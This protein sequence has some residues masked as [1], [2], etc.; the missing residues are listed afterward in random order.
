MQGTRLSV[1]VLGTAEVIQVF[2]RGLLQPFVVP[3]KSPVHIYPFPPPG[4]ALAPGQLRGPL[5][6]NPQQLSPR[7]PNAV[8]DVGNENEEQESHDLTPP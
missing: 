7:L 4:F 6:G 1:V 5:S 8:G 3:R 2:R